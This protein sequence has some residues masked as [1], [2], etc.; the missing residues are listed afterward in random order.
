M[1]I[2]NIIISS[3]LKLKMVQSKHLYLQLMI[4]ALL[5]FI[6][7]RKYCNNSQLPIPLSDETDT[8]KISDVDTF[9]N[10]TF[11]AMVRNKTLQLYIESD[12]NIHLFLIYIHIFSDDFNLCF[13]ICFPCLL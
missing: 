11:T 6:W 12:S 2:I 10:A 8:S 9:I 5:I 1:Y 13:T 7:Y 3:I 4:Y